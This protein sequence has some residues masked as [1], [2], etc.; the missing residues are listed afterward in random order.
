VDWVTGAS[1][2]LRVEALRQVGLF[3]EGVF[4]YHDEVELMWRMRK[5]GWT[6]AIE[7]RS[8]VW[9]IGG[10]ATGVHDREVGGSVRPRVPAYFYRSRARFFG[11]TR[12]RFVATLAFMAWVAGH[13]VWSAR[14]VL[15]LARGSKPIE[16]QLRDPL[17]KAF[18]RHHDSVAAA[19]TPEASPTKAPR[20]I[21]DRWL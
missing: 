19:P 2:M 13:A 1:V 9:H 17:S 20:W 5:A 21:Y 14:R 3:D 11:L 7:P 4:L 16:R 15:G 6:V 18:P 8:R 10:A 12:G